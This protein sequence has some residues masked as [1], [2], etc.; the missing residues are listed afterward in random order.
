MAPGLNTYRSNLSE[1][2]LGLP[3]SNLEVYKNASLRPLVS[4][5]KGDLFFVVGT[6]DFGCYM[7]TI[8]II[9]DLIRADKQFDL[10]LL[11]DQGHGALGYS[12][13]YYL[14]R[15]V[16]YFLDHLPPANVE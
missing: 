3:Q 4:Q 16:R 1:N 10:L 12:Q 8:Q 5:L 14:E 7:D 2:Y 13:K 11:P 15:V 9:E 6:N